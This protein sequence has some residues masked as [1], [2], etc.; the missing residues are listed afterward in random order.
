LLPPQTP[1]ARAQRDMHGVRA[2]MKRT[3]AM[4]RVPQMR[5]EWLPPCAFARAPSP[6]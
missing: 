3:P 4:W 5:G 6:A 1:Q 2:P